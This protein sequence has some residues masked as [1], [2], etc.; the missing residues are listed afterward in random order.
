MHRKRICSTCKQAK[1]ESE[2]GGY[3]NTSRPC[4]ACESKRVVNARW[5]RISLIKLRQE[6]EGD[7]QRLVQK[8]AVLAER[9]KETP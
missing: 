4:K 6:V 8:K 5:R 3:L 9:I 2:F 1:D 7:E